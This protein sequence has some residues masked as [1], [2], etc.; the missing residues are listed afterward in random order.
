MTIFLF[1]NLYS[2]INKYTMFVNLAKYTMML[3][4]GIKK[5]S[6]RPRQEKCNDLPIWFIY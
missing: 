6:S 2:Y 1:L 5:Y 3:K 4:K